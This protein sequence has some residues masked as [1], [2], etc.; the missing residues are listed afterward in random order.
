MITCLS[1]FSF[2]T[3][4]IRKPKGFKGIMTFSELV[5]MKFYWKLLIIQN[6]EESEKLERER[7]TLAINPGH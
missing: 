6:M 2:H 3:N 7:K 5:C 1:L 4:I